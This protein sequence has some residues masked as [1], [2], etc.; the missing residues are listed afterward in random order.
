MSDD[1][2]SWYRLE[3]DR[4]AATYGAGGE[5]PPVVFLHGWA[6]GSRAYKRAV[7]RLMRRGCRVFAPSLPGFG[8]TGDLPGPSVSIA[9]Y[10]AWVDAFMTAVGIEEPALVVGHS[11]GGGVAIKL[12]QGYPERVGYLVLL[13]SVGVVSD[14][15]IWEWA[16]GLAA[17]LVPTRD[18][19][20]TMRAMRDD[21]VANLV[22]NPMGL[23]RAGELA[24][25]TNLREEL[26]ELRERGL[27]VLALM[28]TG[29]GVIPRAAFE[30]LCNAVGTEGRTV[31]GRHSWLLA[32][33]DSF[34]EVLA[35][36]VEVRV[37]RHQAE[38]APGRAAE[39][40][41]AL[42]AT[43][44]PRRVVATLLDGAS[45][46]WL[47]SA[48]PAV[49]AGDLALCHPEFGAGE[50]R[51]VARPIEGPG[52][53]RLTVVAAD[54]HGLLAD[55]AGVLAAHGLSITEGS[56][57]T[58]GARGL[59]LH[60][61]SVANADAVAP[62]AC[63]RL[64]DDLRAVASAGEP[65]VPGFTPVGRAIVTVD[66]SGFDQSLVRVTANDQIGLLWA[67]CRWFAGHKVGIESLHA[68]TDEGLAQDV[69]LVRGRFDPD[70]LARHLGTDALVRS[71][72]D[73]A[74]APS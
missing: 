44:L 73:A 26:T 74:T 2:L 18:G 69:F 65:I 36:V 12:A 39:I 66:G 40:A 11:F 6:L 29:D 35:N 43:K 5:G 60:A 10:A 59:A 38:A 37:A 27:P 55:T 9:D 23:V 32:D 8:G 16:I 34:D 51:A 64:G 68:T 72:G 70:D 63:E 50:V 41:R 46:L 67:I 47:M 54:R 30:A 45:P 14:R 62:A 3:V 21:F 15:P 56:A 57:M 13:N 53:V 22:R 61:L 58:W 28:T 49:L 1:R 17:E 19:I 42:Q 33:P 48:P 31:P 24:R 52:T 25:K 71:I 4:R 7:R 20:E